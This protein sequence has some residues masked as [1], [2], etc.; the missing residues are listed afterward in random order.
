MSN[1]MAKGTIY[2]KEHKYLIKRLRKARLDLGLTQKEVGK[3]LK[4]SQTY[5]SK[6]ELGERK[7]DVV[8]LQKLA[9]I[10]K[11]ELSYFVKKYK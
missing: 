3:K 9:K 4:T 11:K 8:L 1:A 5:I 2:T 7:I 10:Y 6:I